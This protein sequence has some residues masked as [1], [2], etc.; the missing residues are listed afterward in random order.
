MRT[1]TLLDTTLRDGV[2]GYG[3]N[4]T[5]DDKLQIAHRLD[6]IGIDYVEG[7]FPHSNDREA[8]FFKK[9]KGETFHHARI[10]AFG[11]TCRPQSKAASDPAI[12]GL[13][14]ADTEAVVVVGKSW[15]AHVTEILG[16]TRQENLRMITDSIETLKR[17]GR[18]VIFDLEHFFDGYRQNREY[19]LGVLKAA[20][21]AGAEVLVLCDTNG[22]TL[23]TEVR[24]II[25]DLPLDELAPMG[26]HFHND[27]GTAVANTLVGIEAGAVHAQGTINGWGERCG[28]ANL[29]VVIP[30][31]CLKM[32]LATSTNENLAELTSLSRF[33]SEK[34]N[35]I[36]D[37][38]QPYV[39]EAAFSHK[40]GLHADAL[41][42]ADH[43]MEH[44]DS[45]LVGNHRQIVLSELAG[46]STIVTKMSRYGEFNKSSREVAQLLRQLK[47]REQEGYE[48]EAAEAS[49]DLLM[50]KCL[51]IYTPLV[52]LQNYHLESYKFGEA[53]SKTVGRI[54]LRRDGIELMGAAVRLGP[55]ET[56][57]AALRDALLPRFPFLLTIK[58]I[59]YRVRILNPTAAA[60]AKVRVFI[61][62]TDG[63]T[64]WD[65]VGVSEN[66]VEA[67]WQAIVDALEYYYNNRVLA[68]GGAGRSLI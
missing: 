45:R 53:P 40:A 7:G 32:G 39:G 29:C 65:T 36:P 37:K 50:R 63:E 22:G 35:V 38:R 8:A 28:N 66:I 34:A 64:S 19:A 48:Y 44:I 51:N 27:G 68:E 61:T 46:K 43:L 17:E 9:L 4:F 30:N 52:E 21:A 25:G 13:L 16:T 33:V 5:L 59:D 12:Q 47:E 42:K 10:A 67:S 2:Q 23:P 60:A 15:D 14:Q 11:Y 41:S 49:F 18:E 62:T 57:D 55:V 1:I 58:L 31:I 20:A 54:L 56:L 26:V 6:D 3:I 24:R